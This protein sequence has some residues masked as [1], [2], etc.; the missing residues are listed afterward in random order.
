MS[1][2]DDDIEIF[3]PDTAGFLI[4]GLTATQIRQL[5]AFYFSQ[6]KDVDLINLEAITKRM[7]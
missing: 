7:L 1:K 5:K 6:T 4:E 3:D 2:P